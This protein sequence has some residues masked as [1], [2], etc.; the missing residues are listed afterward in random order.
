M[1][2]QSAGGARASGGAVAGSARTG[3]GLELGMLLFAVVTVTAADAVVDLNTSNHV[4]ADVITYGAGYALLWLAAHIVVRILAPYA[5]PLLLPCVALL[6]G[7]GLVLI[8]RLDIAAAVK[9]R[10]NGDPPP[11]SDASVQIV[12]AGLGLALFVATLV[13]IRN[14]KT[15]ARY[16]YTLAFA[17]LLFLALPV[18]L[19]SRFSLVNG[20]KIWIKLPGFSIQPGEFAKLA[21]L[22]FFAAYLVDKR[23][24]LSLASRRIAGIDL[25][26]GRDLGPVLMAWA[27]S[28]LVLIGE[29]DLGTSLLFFGIFVV[30]LYIATERTSW[31]LIGVL[32]FIGGAYIAYQSF[33]HVQTR[34]EFWLH[35]FEHRDTATQIIQS[36]FGLATGGLFGTG[37]GHGHPDLVPFAKTDFI[38]S[39]VGE[40][41]GMFG[42]VAVL[43]VYA[44]VVERGF[45]AALLV[46]DSFGKLLAAGLAF[47]LAWQVFVVV[48]GV[49]KLIPLTGL[50]TPFLSYGGSSLVA[51]FALIGLLLRVSDAARRPAPPPAPKPPLQEAM[52]EVVRP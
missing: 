45:R 3:R 46:R 30:M 22:V 44:V 14:H 47:S 48:G 35:P 15:L 13:I 19:P 27:A 9:A 21:L 42:L 34:V 43:M 5:D 33:G 37:L 10:Q 12:W 52:T 40:E 28:V 32:L 23:D 16:A 11:G 25:P 8:R 31:L 39:A 36:Q 2:V 49:T 29:R 4:S 50:T 41:L 18:F 1:S 20:A 26:R 17:G 7:L 38:M 51:N 24:V 6:N